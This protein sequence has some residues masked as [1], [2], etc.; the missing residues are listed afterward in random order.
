MK[1][2]FFKVVVMYISTSEFQL[3]SSVKMMHSALWPA[4]NDRARSTESVVKMITGPGHANIPY[5]FII[6]INK[7]CFQ[8]NNMHDSF[9]S[10]SL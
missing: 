7:S 2:T 4:S 5:E 3:K 9:R 8:I 10:D 6:K 1:H